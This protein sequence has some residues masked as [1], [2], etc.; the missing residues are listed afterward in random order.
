Q[1]TKIGVCTESFGLPSTADLAAVSAKVDKE[2]TTIVTTPTRR[3]TS[4][5]ASPKQTLGDNS[6][7]EVTV[8]QGVQ[9][10]A[11]S[12]R[13]VLVGYDVKL[14]FESGLYHAA[15]QIERSVSPLYS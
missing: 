14:Y 9:H 7:M 1:S 6:C 11:R 13:P 3:P 12:S 15:A 2:N 8:Q 5:G 10:F 4:R